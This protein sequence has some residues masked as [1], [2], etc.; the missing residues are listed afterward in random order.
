MMAAPASAASIDCAEICCGVIGSASDMVG[1]CMAPVIAHEMMT[2]LF[3]GLCLL[4]SQGRT[5][6]IF[7]DCQTEK[8]A[9]G[10]DGNR[11]PQHMFDA[12]ALRNVS[13][14]DRSQTAAE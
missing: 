2:L 14:D 8:K 13:D 5:K 7:L 12:E 3:I 11:Q 4:R 1:V 10:H 9:G 6:A